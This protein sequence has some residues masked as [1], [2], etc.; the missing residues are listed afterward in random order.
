MAAGRRWR[1]GALQAGVQAGS[2]VSVECVAEFGSGAARRSLEQIEHDGLEPRVSTPMSSS[3]DEPTR[4]APEA[5]A[6]MARRAE[7]P[8]EAVASAETH[9]AP[10]PKA[11]PKRRVQP[12]G[13]AAPSARPEP[14]WGRCDDCQRAL[15]VK[16]R[17][18]DG[19]PF[20][21][22]PRYP[23]CT[24]AR[25]VP[26]GLEHLLPDTCVIRREVSW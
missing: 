12:K 25:Q 18:R 13:R 16:L 6:A 11:E 15:V 7:E 3:C 26:P 17:R 23:R 2:L 9:S 5:K 1:S 8:P 22:C 21:S 24:F 4:W 10:E 20:L 14:T 19:H